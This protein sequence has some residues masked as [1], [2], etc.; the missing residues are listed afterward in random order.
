MLSKAESSSS[1]RIGTGAINYDKIT[2]ILAPRLRDVPLRY[3]WEAT[4]PRMFAV[5]LA[6][7]LIPGSVS[8]LNSVFEPVTFLLETLLCWQL[9]S[10]S[11]W[12]DE[13]G[14][15]EKG[16]DGPG[17]LGPIRPV[18]RGDIPAN[19]MLKG[20]VVLAVACCATGLILVL[21]ATWR[22]R[23]ALWVPAIFI[24]VGAACVAAAFAYTMGR[25][26]Y[27]YRGWGDFASFFFFGPIAGGGG[28]WLYAGTLD[29]LVLLPSCGA[30]ILLAQ[31]I[32]LQNLRDFCN[33]TAHGK[34]TTAVILG[35]SKAEIY[36]Y[37]MTVAAC[38]CYVLFPVCAS[39]SDPQNYLFVVTFV[40]LI[41]HCIDFRRIVSSEDSPAKLDTLMSPL[42]RAM[43]LTT[44][45][46]CL[47]I[48]L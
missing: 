13:Y 23:L 9:L 41:K 24:G 36:H 46:F 37:L 18:Q 38:L 5:W 16:V 4:R 31:T 35:R 44:I 21:W 43:A 34:R 45:A 2:S 33:D 14:D 8:F 10:L 48:N 39:L 19:T 47:F 7:G 22:L 20:C 6:A 1:V 27:G 3:W 42:V 25:H 30:A 17:R 12:A 26:P 11:C 28:Y 32:N 15:F 40:P 29:W